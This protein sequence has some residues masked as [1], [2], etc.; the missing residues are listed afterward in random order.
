M[1]HYATYNSRKANSLDYPWTIRLQGVSA[2]RRQNRESYV[3]G[4]N[5]GVRA[6]PGKLM[7]TSTYPVVKQN[8]FQDCNIPGN[9]DLQ[10]VTRTK[11]NAHTT[12]KVQVVVALFC[13][14]N[15]QFPPRRGNGLSCI[16]SHPRHFVKTFLTCGL[17]H[18]RSP[19]GLFS[20]RPV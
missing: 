5:P 10:S 8:L 19:V 4:Q 13:H 20:R 2:E 9:L 7:D 15:D 6:V 3:P 11:T 1:N 18:S 16:L 14:G 12:L 17:Y